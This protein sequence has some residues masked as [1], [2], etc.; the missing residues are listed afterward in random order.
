MLS[1][2]FQSGQESA[3]N[4]KGMSQWYA[5]REDLSSLKNIY[6]LIF[7]GLSKRSKDERNKSK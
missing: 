2:S 1:D 4:V 6:K 5:V 3:F 7:I